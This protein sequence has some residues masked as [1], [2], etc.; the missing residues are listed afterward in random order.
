M[1][2]ELQTDPVSSADRS[3]SGIMEEQPDVQLQ[4]ENPSTA[5]ASDAAPTAAEPILID[6]PVADEPSSVSNESSSLRQEE[7]TTSGVSRVCRDV[8]DCKFYYPAGTGTR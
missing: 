4:H 7:E 6:N 8:L 1:S 3:S 5:S 2:R